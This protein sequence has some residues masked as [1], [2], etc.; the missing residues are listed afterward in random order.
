MDKLLRKEMTAAD[1]GTHRAAHASHGVGDMF[2]ERSGP[3]VPN[4]CPGTCPPGPEEFLVPT[5]PATPAR[6]GTGGG[7]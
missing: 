3:Y 6:I 5:P 2:G 7:G 1:L 4:H